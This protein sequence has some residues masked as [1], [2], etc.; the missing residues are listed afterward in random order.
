MQS[1]PAKCFRNGEI[2]NTQAAGINCQWR[3][4]QRKRA[5]IE[6]H[7]ENVTD[8]IWRAIYFKSQK[9]NKNT[10]KT[11]PKKSQAQKILDRVKFL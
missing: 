4:N 9:Q 8:K 11:T 3:T 1:S 5:T 10:N 6:Q 7:N 2:K